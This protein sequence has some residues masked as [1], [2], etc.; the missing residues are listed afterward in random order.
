MVKPVDYLR[1]QRV[2]REIEGR[3]KITDDKIWD[4]YMKDQ[5]MNEYERLEEIRRRA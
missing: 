1:D 2:K 3:P 5:T 4:K